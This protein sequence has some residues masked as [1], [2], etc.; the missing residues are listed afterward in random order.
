[1][2]QGRFKSWYVYDE[3]Y[4]KSLVKY[5][6]YN[7][8]KAKIGQ[9]RWAMSSKEDIFTC[10]NYKLIDNIDLSKKFSEKEL[11]NI[12]NLFN[13]KLIVVN[14]LVIPKVKEKLE[15][16]F[17]NKHREIAIAN[18]IKDGY[19]QI[20]I[21]KYLDLS[22]IAISKIYKIYR[23]KVE[24]FNKLRDKGI[25]WSYSKDISYEKAG[26]NLLIEYL[27]KYADFDDIQQGFELFGKRVMKRVWEDKLKS[28]KR[29]IKLNFMIARVFLGMLEG[30]NFKLFS[31]ALLYTDDIE[32]DNIEYLE[33]IKI[34]SKEQIRNFFQ[35][36]LEKSK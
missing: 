5:I 6:E 20:E 21:A 28:D 14:E 26:E 35:L 29:F 30:I 8:I 15:V 27:F 17:K 36:E 22:T 4:L 9:F 32:D 31:V 7:P 11:Q 18:A 24:L 19:K 34:L 33:P 12:D 1:M 13:A 16:H 2:W 25:F 10:L 23:Q 3:S